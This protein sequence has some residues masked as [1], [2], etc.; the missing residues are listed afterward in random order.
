[1]DRTLNYIEQRAELP[2]C[3]VEETRNLLAKT[4]KLVAWVVWVDWET[5]LEA[6]VL[7]CQR[8][9]PAWLPGNESL[10]VLG[11]YSLV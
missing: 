2:G 8:H 6:A 11:A 4:Q 1:M 7:L 9:P 3:F 10:G 5:R